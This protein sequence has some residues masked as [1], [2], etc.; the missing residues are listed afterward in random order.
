MNKSDLQNATGAN[1]VITQLHPDIKLNQGN[2][3]RQKSRSG[4]NV[5]NGLWK[6]Q[7]GAVMS[8]WDKLSEEE[9]LGTEGL[10]QKLTSLI[11]ER[12]DPWLRQPP[13]Q[14]IPCKDRLL[15]QA[16]PVCCSRLG[17]CGRPA[18]CGPVCETVQT[19]PI[20]CLQCD[21]VGP[22]FGANIHSQYT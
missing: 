15:K 4:M 17:I 8:N 7:M 22:L 18:G 21:S 12:H 20:P 3:K 10:E 2:Y 16:T 9:I 5:N 19:V 11:Q 6:Q 14:N 13:G 1:E